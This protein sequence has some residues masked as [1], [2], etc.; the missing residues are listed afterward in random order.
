MVVRCFWRDCEFRNKKWGADPIDTFWV[1]ANA[2][3]ADKTIFPF[4][5]PKAVAESRQLAKRFKKVAERIGNPARAYCFLVA[6][7]LSTI[8][9][10]PVHYPIHQLW[11]AYSPFEAMAER[12]IL[13]LNELASFSLPSR[14]EL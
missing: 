2:E 7:D 9:P 14:Q 12:S 13:S 11:N 10:F 8:G 5:R 3:E 6:R 4:L 1:E